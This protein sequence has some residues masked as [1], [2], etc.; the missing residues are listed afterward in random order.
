MKEKLPIQKAR[1][2]YRGRAYKQH[3]RTR[4]GKPYLAG[5][6]GPIHTAEPRYN[7]GQEITHHGK[8][9]TVTS[10][11]RTMLG[12]PTYRIEFEGDKNPSFIKEGDLVKSQ[13]EE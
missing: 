12:E 8:R 7:V 5:R 3:I 10:V 13:I 2:Y 4:E 6:G 1:G 9:G 11:R